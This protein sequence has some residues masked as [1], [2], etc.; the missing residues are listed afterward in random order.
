RVAVEMMKR[1]ALDYLVK[2]VN[3]IEFVPA[4]VRRGLEQL[5]RGRL[6]D[7][8]EKN[9]RDSEARYRHLVSAL[10]I[11][12]YTC[13]TEGRITLF[14]EAA[15]ALWGREPVLGHDRWCGSY[16][17]YDAEGSPVLLDQC[18]LAQAVR[19]GRPIRDVELIIE[20]PDHTRRH[21]LAF[22]EPI[23]DAA[24]AVTGA[25]NMLVDITESKQL[26]EVEL[27]RDAAERANQAKADFLAAL[28]HELR[29]PLGPVLLLADEGSHNQE[30]PASVRADFEMI[31]KNVALEARL[32]DDLLDLTRITNGKMPM[33]LRPVELHEVL[34]DA[35]NIV[36]EKIKQKRL[37]LNLELKVGNPKI[38]ADAVRLQQVLWNVLQNAVKFAPIDGRIQVETDVVPASRVVVVRVTDSGIGMTGEELDR[39]F[40]SFNQGDHAPRGGS[41][42]FGGLGLGLTI[43]RKLLDLHS[44]CIS[45]ASEG[46]GK[47]SVFTIELPLLDPG[48]PAAATEARETS[49]QEILEIALPPQ[50]CRILLVEDHEASRI[51]LTGLLKRRRYDVMAAASVHEALELANGSSIDIVVSDIGLPDGN[52][53]ELMM[54]LRRRFPGLVGIAMSGYGA[55]EDIQRSS[56]AG[57]IAHLVKPVRMTALQSALA[58]AFAAAKRR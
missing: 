7:A 57:F 16:R 17:L 43:S 18:P 2:D 9:R 30:L 21:V 58:R 32:I 1:G 45:A 44:G 12:V 20:R 31:A 24:G 52:G 42:L 36:Q 47:G 40:E 33:D 6:L 41:R 22:P 54:E 8:A 56:D 5:E 23:R 48:A 3:F 29:N 27:A 37:T 50:G 26:K 13:D 28:S 19:D 4:V 39:I 35:L 34:Q 25:V 15:A 11:A 14:N 49:I 53:Y 10:P 51:T 38:M 46:R 55:E